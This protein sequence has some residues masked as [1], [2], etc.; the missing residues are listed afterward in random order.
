MFASA[1]SYLQKPSMWLLENCA[2]SYNFLTET[3]QFIFRLD[4]LFDVITRYLRNLNWGSFDGGAK[5]VL[6]LY[7]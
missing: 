6:I 7:F 1:K 3:A 4:F 2:F 5:F